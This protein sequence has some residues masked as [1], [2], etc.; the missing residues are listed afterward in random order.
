KSTFLIDTFWIAAQWHAGM[1]LRKSTFTGQYYLLL[2]NNLKHRNIGIFTFK[3]KSCRRRF[4]RCVG[5]AGGNFH[6]SGQRDITRAA[7]FRIERQ[8]AAAE[9]HFVVGVTK[10]RHAH[11]LGEITNKL[12]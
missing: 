1:T 2:P 3:C 5:G 12:R 10:W 8:N 9:T 7:A 4:I 6:S 11:A